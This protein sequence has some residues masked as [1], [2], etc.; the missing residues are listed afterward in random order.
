MVHF[1]GGGTGRGLTLG[2]TSVPPEGAFPGGSFCLGFSVLTALLRNVQ[3]K[4]M[5]Y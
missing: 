1:A 5:S 3:L 4:T 2:W